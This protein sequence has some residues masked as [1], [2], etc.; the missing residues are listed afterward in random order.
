MNVRLPKT[1]KKLYTL[2]EKFAQ[3]E[4]G[5]KLPREK[6]CINVDSEDEDESA[7][8]K[9]GK[10]RNKKPRDKAVVT[11]EGSGMP[12]TGKKAKVEAP[13]KE[14]A[15][16][17]A[18]REAAVAE[19]V[20]KGDGPYYKIHRTKGHDL[21]EC[22]QV[23]QLA[24]KQRAEY[25]KRDKEKGQN[26]AGAPAPLAR[27]ARD[28]PPSPA[29]PPPPARSSAARLP[30]RRSA[31]APLRRPPDSPAPPPAP[32]A[33][34]SP[35]IRRAA[36]RIRPAPTPRASHLAPSPPAAASSPE[37]P[38]G[39]R[40]VLDPAGWDEIH[41][42][43][44]QTLRPSRISSSRDRPVPL[45]VSVMDKPIKKLKV[46]KPAKDPKVADPEKQTMSKSFHQTSEAAMDDPPPEERP[47]TMASMNV[48][49]ENAKPPSPAQPAQ[50]TRDFSAQEI[51]SGYLNRL[52]SSCDFEAGMVNL[53]KERF[54]AELNMKESQVVDLR[55]NI[56]SQQA[57][58]SMAK[59][60]LTTSLE[61]I[62]KLKKDFSTERTSW[63]SEK[64]ALLKR[65]EDAKVALKPALEAPS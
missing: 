55:Q 64:A 62:E 20:G 7:S 21:Q 49:P 27:Q 60:E 57:E 13:G 53:M 18:C 37:K 9:K 17:A 58:T 16:C 34:A 6:D 1:V 40:P 33:A 32:Y 35:R 29:A 22:Y 11:V 56:Q 41:P 24:K 19:Q 8:Q 2:V 46:N 51:H 4:E 28:G 31:G 10:K 5:R 52:H 44:N 45:P 48:D 38:A 30:R 23:E 15:A 43:P 36:T 61:N 3:M 39:G 65:A 42:V 54:E 14:A 59:E 12:T 63:D 26:V 47:V 50:E 25:D